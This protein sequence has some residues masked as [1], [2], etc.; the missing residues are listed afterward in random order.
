MPLSNCNPSAA[1]PV[2]QTPFITMPFSSAIRFSLSI[3]VVLPVPASPFTPIYLSLEVNIWCTASPC[4][5][6]LVFTSLFPAALSSAFAMLSTF[7]SI[8]I[9]S[10]IVKTFSFI[11]PLPVLTLSVTAFSISIFF[12][13]VK[14]TSFDFPLSLSM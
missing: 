3:M 1:L 9:L 4:S 14:Y 11:T 5:P 10:S 8:A 12:S 7:S 6:S 2:K 13:V